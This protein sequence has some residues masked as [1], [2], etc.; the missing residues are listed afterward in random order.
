MTIYGLTD[1]RGKDLD[2]EMR[3]R[4]A[5]HTGRVRREVDEYLRV[6]WDDQR[7]KFL[8]LDDAAPG[9]PE[10]AYVMVVQEPD[11]RFRDVDGRTF[12]T[13]RKLRFGHK[14]AKEELERLQRERERAAEHR[15]ADFAE[16]LA[17]DFRHIGHAI[18]SSVGWRA[19]ADVPAHIQAARDAKREEI[20][21]VAR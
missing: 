2:T 15:R 6:V 3:L 1:P 14:R 7:Q 18:V 5:A 13:L 12:E 8:V 4:A 11:G 16:S 10:A 17:K 21:E 19:R 20:R 9:G